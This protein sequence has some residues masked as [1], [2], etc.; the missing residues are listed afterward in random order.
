MDTYCGCMEK[1][2]T[3]KVFKKTLKKEAVHL[4]SKTNIDTVVE[5]CLVII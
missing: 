1:G 3:I 5:Y 2:N 4:T